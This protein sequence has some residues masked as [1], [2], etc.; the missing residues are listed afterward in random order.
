M[1]ANNLHLSAICW[2]VSSWRGSTST[3]TCQQ[4]EQHPPD[5]TS[6]SSNSTLG[7][8]KITAAATSEQHK[9]CVQAL[10][11]KQKLSSHA[12]TS[13]SSPPRPYDSSNKPEIKHSPA[14]CSAFLSQQEY[15]RKTASCSS[16][17]L[18]GSFSLQ[19]GM[20][21]L[22]TTLAEVSVAFS[23][24]LLVAHPLQSSLGTP[25]I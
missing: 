16:V 6:I 15:E 18:R 17:H 9:H 19:R 23:F 24:S 21:A 13:S 4:R 8:P 20:Q 2:A 25:C 1:K 14:S 12:V 11:A 22:D 10:P 3:P 7:K 5:S